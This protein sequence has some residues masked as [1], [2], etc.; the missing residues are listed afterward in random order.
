[1]LKKR[2]SVVATSFKLN[3]IPIMDAVFIFIFF[4]LMSAQFIKIY[5]HAGDAPVVSEAPPIE[6]NNKEPL[7]LKLKVDKNRI[8]I[9]TG[10]DENELKRFDLTGD[11]YDYIK[12]NDLMMELKAKKAKKD[13]DYV[14]IIPTSRV[15]YEQIVKVMDAV[16]F[17]NGPKTNNYDPSK[18]QDGKVFDKVVL[19]PIE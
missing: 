1:M 12:L 7:N 5:E 4:L 9:T 14:I 3:L 6:E 19:E 17:V 10:L 2:G 11:E 15:K 18:F 16:R 13:D 8:T